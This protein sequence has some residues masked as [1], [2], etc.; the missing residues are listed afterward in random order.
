MGDARKLPSGRWQAR[1]YDLDGKRR[2]LDTYSTKR[3]AE[4]A[5]RRAEVEQEQAKR[6]VL[7][8]R[9][10]VRQYA[11]IFLRQKARTVVE[12]TLKNH[13]SGLRLHILPVFGDRRLPSIRHSEVA[14]WVEHLPSEGVRRSAYGTL[15]ALMRAA[16]RDDLIL[17]SPCGVEGALRYSGSSRPTFTPEQAEQVIAALPDHYAIVATVQYG[18]AL[19]ASE[20]LALD[21]SDV[22]LDTGRVSV[23][24]QY[25]KGQMRHRTK[26]KVE[27]VAW[28]TQDALEALKAHW[29]A[30]PAIGSTACFRTPRVARA[31][32]DGYS[33]AIRQAAD[34]ATVEGFTSHAFR[35]V[36]LAAY[37][38]HVRDI[39]LT[40]SRGGHGDIRSALIYQKQMDERPA[41]LDDFKKSRRA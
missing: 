4:R 36:D 18:A 34:A 41:A 22:D 27:R 24:K 2:S 6:Q 12:D 1:Y 17:K 37:Q 30:N 15:S 3:D 35:H 23:T 16:V 26:T 8:Q 39:V 5:A 31:S 40:M 7:D 28:L 11:P 20:A 14:D 25:V 38:G 32:Y 9:T 29:K 13:E 33:T 19:R 21:W 10:T